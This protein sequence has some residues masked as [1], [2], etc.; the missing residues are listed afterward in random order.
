MRPQGCVCRV[1]MRV[2]SWLHPP[3]SVMCSF[4]LLSTQ[5]SGNFLSLFSH[6]FSALSSTLLFSALLC[7]PVFKVLLDLL[8]LTKASLPAHFS[9]AFWS[10]ILIFKAKCQTAAQQLYQ[11]SLSLLSVPQES[12]Y[13]FRPCLRSVRPKIERLE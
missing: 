5:T 1:I 10:W 3:I 11:V 9:L 7:F 12:S 2:N 6:V 4:L 8:I 13:S